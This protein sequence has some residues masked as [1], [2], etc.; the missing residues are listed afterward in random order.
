MFAPGVTVSEYVALPP[1]VVVAVEPDAADI[2][3]VSAATVKLVV[4]VAGP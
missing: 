4:A 1:A 2:V 3:N